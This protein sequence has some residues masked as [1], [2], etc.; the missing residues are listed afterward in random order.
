LLE[1]LHKLAGGQVQTLADLKLLMAVAEF[2]DLLALYKAF[3]GAEHELPDAARDIEDRARAIPAEDIAP[4][5]LVSGSDLL[6]IGLAEGPIFKEILDEVYYRQLNLE[7][8]NHAEALDL[9]RQ[10]ASEN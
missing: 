4:A 6:E 7:L 9:A 8:S 1:G 3:L 2:A 5:P 10:L